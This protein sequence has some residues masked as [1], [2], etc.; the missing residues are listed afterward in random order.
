LC[1]P[2]Y[3]IGTHYVPIYPSKNSYKLGDDIGNPFVAFLVLAKRDRCYC[4]FLKESGI[5]TAMDNDGKITI[6]YE[7]TGVIPY[8]NLEYVLKLTVG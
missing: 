3:L 1:L 4:P 7:K 8:L 6:A 5:V 2:T